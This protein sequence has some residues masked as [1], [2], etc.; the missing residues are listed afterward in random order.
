MSPVSLGC[1]SGLC[2]DAFTLAMPAIGISVSGP[3]SARSTF[4]PS[5]ISSEIRFLNSII[6]VEARCV[7][8]PGVSTVKP[9]NATPSCFTANVPRSAASGRPIIRFFSG[10]RTERS[11]TAKSSVCAVSCP[12]R[13]SGSSVPLNSGMWTSLSDHPTIACGWTPRSRMRSGKSI[14]TTVT[15]PAKSGL[16]FAKGSILASVIE[17][18][19]LPQIASMSESRTALSDTCTFAWSVSAKSFPS[20]PGDSAASVPVTIGSRPP[21]YSTSTSTVADPVRCGAFTNRCASA[22]GT[23][24]RTRPAARS[25][26]SESPD[27]RNAESD[28]SSARQSPCGSAHAGVVPASGSKSTEP[29][30]ERRRTSTSC[31]STRTRTTSLHRRSSSIAS[32]SGCSGIGCTRVIVAPPA[33][34]PASI[35]PPSSAET[36]TSSSS[37]SRCIVVGGGLG[38]ASAAVLTT[39]RS[40]RPSVIAR[41]VKGSSLDPGPLEGGSLYERFAISPSFTTARIQGRSISTSPTSSS[42]ARSENGRGRAATRSTRRKGSPPSLASTATFESAIIIGQASTSTV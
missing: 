38:V 1:V 30:I 29:A 26:P 2:I 22:S 33:R 32:S 39:V 41:D 4:D 36:S 21:S 35:A 40:T 25:F 14:P 7:R 12:L 16:P 37:A 13:S 6:T 9:W 27:T 15:G 10:R 17:T 3:T 42:P 24:A 34:R 20:A 18:F 19:P 5:V 28:T 8:D 11:K 31:P 23:L